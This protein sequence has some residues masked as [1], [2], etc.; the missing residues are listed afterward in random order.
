MNEMQLLA[1]HACGS[2][3]NCPSV[4]R[5]PGGELALIGKEAPDELQ[6]QL[7]AGVG[8]GKGERLVVFPE[9]LL[10]DAG[11]VCADD[12]AVTQTCGSSFKRR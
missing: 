11:Y 5:L 2:E 1:S 3:V 12:G 10:A 6:G 7:P 8:I 9:S 4:L